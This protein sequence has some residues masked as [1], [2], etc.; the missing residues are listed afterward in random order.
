M[1][2]DKQI[3]DEL[4]RALILIHPGPCRHCSHK[5]RHA[6]GLRQIEEP[7]RLL[8][9]QHRNIPIIDARKL[10]PAYRAVIRTLSRNRK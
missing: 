7:C 6:K 3:N 10:V 2:Q 4:D 5:F 8:R 1:S 9:F